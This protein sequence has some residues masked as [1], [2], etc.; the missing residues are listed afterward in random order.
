MRTKEARAIMWSL[1]SG[2]SSMTRLQVCGNAMGYCAV[3]LAAFSPACSSGGSPAAQATTVCVNPGGSGGC[4]ATI[5]LAV[6]AAAANG[7]V[8]VAA[9]TYTEDVTIGKPLSLMGAGAGQSFIDATNLANGILLDGLS[10]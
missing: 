7:V 1:R 5:Q 10:N 2:G 9:G 6:N 8:N 3:L 4:Y